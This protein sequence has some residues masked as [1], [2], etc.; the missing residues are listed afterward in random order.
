M[1]VFRIITLCTLLL[2]SIDICSVDQVKAL[3]CLCLLLTPVSWKHVVT[4]PSQQQMPEM[5]YEVDSKNFI[6]NHNSLRKREIRDKKKSDFQR[7]RSVSKNPSH[8]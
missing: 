7:K 6:I 2:T 8:R 5:H 3:V 1:R 4:I